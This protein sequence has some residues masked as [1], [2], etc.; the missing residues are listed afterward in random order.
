MEGWGTR[1]RPRAARPHLQREGDVNGL[2]FWG[3][4]VSVVNGVVLSSSLR[5][6]LSLLLWVVYVLLSICLPPPLLW[7]GSEVAELSC[8]SRCHAG[9]T[10]LGDVP[11]PSLGVESDPFLRLIGV[12][13][14]LLTACRPELTGVPLPWIGLEGAKAPPPPLR[15]TH[16]GAVPDGEG[17]AGLARSLAVR[18]LWEGLLHV[19]VWVG[20]LFR[21]ALLKQSSTALAA[22]LIWSVRM[23]GVWVVVSWDMES[24][25]L[26]PHLRHQV[27]WDVPWVLLCWCR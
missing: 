9:A 7:R 27:A 10:C 6:V 16:R 26:I 3:V 22:D 18:H 4:R 8:C 17:G 13:I 24:H 21:V 25:R 1:P 11:P 2:F 14:L 19:A 20:W 5:V 15:V 12:E 23:W